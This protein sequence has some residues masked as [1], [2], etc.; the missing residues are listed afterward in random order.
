MKAF[1][2]YRWP[3]NVRELQNVIERAAI[4]TQKRRITLDDLGGTFSDAAVEPEA[5]PIR[6]RRIF[7]RE[8]VVNALRETDGNVTRAAE[9]LSTHRR[10][11]QRLM[12]RYA[13][14]KSN[15]S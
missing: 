8:Q 9:L 12:K 5:V 4:M 1:V 11:L 6:K 3:G 15:V 13:I 14:D 2:S 7:D 10:Q